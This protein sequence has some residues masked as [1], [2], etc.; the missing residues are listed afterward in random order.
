MPD[1]FDADTQRHSGH[2][3][4]HATVRST[5]IITLIDSKRQVP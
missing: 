3:T 2:P 5:G 4:K 1:K